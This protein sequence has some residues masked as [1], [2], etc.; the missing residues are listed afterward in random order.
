M[1]STEVIV[2]Q[3]LARV[4]VQVELPHVLRRPAEKAGLGDV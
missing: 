2:E 1:Q 3:L 4:L